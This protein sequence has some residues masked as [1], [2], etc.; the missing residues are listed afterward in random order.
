M[1]DGTLE[2][3]FNIAMEEASFVN[4]YRRHDARKVAA[5]LKPVGGRGFVSAPAR[6]P[7][8][9]RPATLLPPARSKAPV[10]QAELKIGQCRF[11]L[12]E[13]SYRRKSA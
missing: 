12:G 1:F 7:A 3:T 8:P 5:Q 2:S 11:P 4:A 13:Q 10:H 6:P 9:S